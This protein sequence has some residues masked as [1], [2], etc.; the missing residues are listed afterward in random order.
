MG[1]FDGWQPLLRVP[2]K[3]FKVFFKSVKNLLKLSVVNILHTLFLLVLKSTLL[4]RETKIKE[5]M[6]RSFP[7]KTLTLGKAPTMCGSIAYL[8]FRRKAHNF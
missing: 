7:S 1:L 4:S 3:D 8:L 5:M 6:C 2:P